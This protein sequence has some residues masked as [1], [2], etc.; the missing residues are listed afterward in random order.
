M[1]QM[2]LPWLNKYEKTRITRILWLFSALQ[3]DNNL[4]VQDQINKHLHEPGVSNI[5]GTHKS[6]WQDTSCDKHSS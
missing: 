1:Y 3:N 2:Y 6:L 4:S 5:H